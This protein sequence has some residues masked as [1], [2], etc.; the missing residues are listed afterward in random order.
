MRLSWGWA[1]SSTLLRTRRPYPQC[2]PGPPVRMEG[3]RRRGRA[4]LG[5]KMYIS[6]MSEGEDAASPASRCGRPPPHWPKLLTLAARP[7]RPGQWARPTHCVCC[8]GLYSQRSRREVPFL[9]PRDTGCFYLPPACLQVSQP[10]QLHLI[11]I[12]VRLLHQRYTWWRQPGPSDQGTAPSQRCSG[13]R[14]KDL[15]FVRHCT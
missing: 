11:S 3:V 5:T 15:K 10:G 2:H 13:Q 6:G 9:A 8:L 14:Q 12:E 1:E 7:P 4:E